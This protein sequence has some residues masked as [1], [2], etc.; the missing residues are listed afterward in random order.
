V[1][2][3]LGYS[4]IHAFYPNMPK[5][6]RE[7]FDFSNT[8]AGMISSLP[9]LI[10]SLSVPI[11]GTLLRKF[12][13]DKVYQVGLIVSLSMIFS[14]HTSYFL[15]PDHFYLKWLPIIPLIVFGVGHALF[16][17]L[18]S[19]MVPQIIDNNSELLPTCFSIIKVIEGFNI[20]LF[21]QIAGSLR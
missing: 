9:Y 18:L 17:T 20:T 21:Q 7:K 10:A 13:T 12:N 14:T 19:P 4:A 3:S 16:T 11:F 6:L 1:I 5:F 2:N 8:E 15:M